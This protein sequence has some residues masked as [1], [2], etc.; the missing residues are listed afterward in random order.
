MEVVGRRAVEQDDGAGGRLRAERR[1]LAFDLI[2]RPDDVAR[3]VLDRDLAVGDR[4]RHVRVGDLEANGAVL[5]LG[6]DLD[7]VGLIPSRAGQAAGVADDVELAF[8]Q[9]DHLRGVFFVAVGGLDVAG[10]FTLHGEIRPGLRRI[11][12]SRRPR[13]GKRRRQQQNKGAKRE[14]SWTAWLGLRE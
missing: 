6:I 3:G 4:A 7:L 9:G 2:E 11:G 13:R 1:A 10:V 14:S 5:G 12:E 8:A